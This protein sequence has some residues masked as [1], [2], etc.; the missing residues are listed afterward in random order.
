LRTTG[1]PAGLAAKKFH[2]KDATPPE[3]TERFS[4]RNILDDL[5]AQG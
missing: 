1:A 4:D 2:V 5:F 3:S